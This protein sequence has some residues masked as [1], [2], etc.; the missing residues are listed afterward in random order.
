VQQDASPYPAAAREVAWFRDLIDGTNAAENVPLDVRAVLALASAD[1]ANEQAAAE[2]R[3][4]AELAKIAD[5]IPRSDGIYVHQAT[6]YGDSDDYLRFYDDGRVVAATVTST[7][8]PAQVAQWLSW[9]H[10]YSSPGRFELRGREIAFEVTNRYGAIEYHGF[11][12]SLDQIT[13]DTH[14]QI[15]GHEHFRFHEAQFAK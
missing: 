6:G 11:F 15:N 7:G 12:D 4:V 2:R 9:D 3:R 1:L 5:R 8:T 13:M 14:G 10:K